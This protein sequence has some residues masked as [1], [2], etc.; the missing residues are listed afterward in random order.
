LLSLFDGDVQP[1]ESLLPDFLS[2]IRQQEDHKAQS[3]LVG[4]NFSFSIREAK[5][6]LTAM[7][8]RLGLRASQVR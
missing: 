2:S 5:L 1:V 3:K 7:A 8:K 4:T 6:R